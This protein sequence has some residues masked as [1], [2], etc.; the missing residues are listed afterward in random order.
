[1]EFQLK[2]KHGKIYLKL[3]YIGTGEQIHANNEVVVLPGT[4]MKKEVHITK[5]WTGL[6]HLDVSRRDII[7][8]GIVEDYD[9]EDYI[10][11]KEYTFSSPN[12]AASSCLGRITTSAWEDLI[13]NN[14]ESLNTIYRCK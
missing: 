11:V 6:P 1:M 14:G 4:K 3:K 8:K 12:R 13:N 10:F 9:E 5:K 7:S 2:N